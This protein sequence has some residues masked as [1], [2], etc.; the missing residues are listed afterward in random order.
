MVLPLAIPNT[1]TYHVPEELLGVIQWGVRVEVPVRKKFHAGIVVKIHRD[2]PDYTTKPLANVI[3]LQP[4]LTPQQWAF[5]R[6][7]ADYYVCTPGECMIAALPNHLKLTSETILIPAPEY[8][9]NFTALDDREYLIAEALTMQAELSL[10]DA[11]LILQRK[12]VFPVIRSLLDKGAIAVKEEITEK[13]RPKTQTCIRFAEP[14]ASMM[15]RLNE[16]FELTKRSDKQT[17]AILSLFQ[18]VKTKEIVQA[19]DVYTA[20]NTDMPVLRKLQEKGIVEIYSREISRIAGY[21]DEITEAS[22]LDAQQALAIAELS[23]TLRNHTVALL[24]GVTGSGK[25][26]VYVELMQRALKKG[27]QVL[28]LLPEIALTVQVIQRLQR[29]F[30]DDIAVYHSR[31]NHNERVELWSLALA[32]KKII[33]GVRSALFL[34]FKD[35]RLI[36]LDEEHDASFKQ[37]DPNPRYNARDAAIWMASRFGAK[38]ILGTA[39]PALETYQNTNNGKFGLVEMK[40]RFGGL[41][42]PEILIAD[43][44]SELKERKMQ[45]HFTS[46]LLN[47]MKET[48]ER[49]E[50]IILF[51]N[52]R[53][54]APILLCKTCGWT[55]RCERCDVSLTYHKHS[56][57]L[58]CHYCGFYIGKP[59]R[60]NACGSAELTI[61]GLGTERIEDEIQIY[62]PETAIARMDLDTVR[63]RSAHSRILSDF[64][65]GRTKIL[66]GTQMVTKGLDFDNVGLVGVI[67]AD[68]LLAH[69]DFRAAERT[70]QLLTQVAGRAGRKN[71]RGKVVIQTYQ[72][73]HPVLLDVIANNYQNFLR[74]ELD[75]RLAFQYPPYF[76]LISITLKHKDTKR[77]NDAARIFGS[78]LTEQLPNRVFGPAIPP[79]G[80]L[81][82]QYL[83]EFT[84]KLSRDSALIARAKLAIREA[85]AQVQ[86]KAGLSGT[87]I[88]IDVDPM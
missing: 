8:G 16:A 59:S 21:E 77:L 9:D 13:Y 88:V 87:R 36:I 47:E 46:V 79:I 3:D 50:Q 26:R 51:Q 83:L 25:T 60:C 12:N 22:E 45:A 41:E 56:D 81:N 34:P 30:G 78:Y 14:Y 53:G 74:R 28:Y 73:Q 64:E 33:L 49:G 37:D 2:A 76:R 61:A 5:W 86:G 48:L 72:P 23:L 63:T 40:E 66:I 7:L 84:I 42:L 35:L 39:T 17:A 55:A 15:E 54:Y 75:E 57:K 31:L 68:S 32:G 44:R 11:Q 43:M 58:D 70:F 4:I 27:G 52:R 10:D 62:F 85:S 80:R 18:M 29:I 38:V 69:P 71:K 67:S 65:E 20:A 1:Y 19:K 82:D 24:H 6:W